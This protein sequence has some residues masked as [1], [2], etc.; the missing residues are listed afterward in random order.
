MGGPVLQSVVPGL[1]S[2]GE[3]KTEKEVKSFQGLAEEGRHQPLALPAE[4]GAKGNEP[5]PQQKGIQLDIQG[6]YH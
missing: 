1:S 3:E 4:D 5:K 2:F 6:K